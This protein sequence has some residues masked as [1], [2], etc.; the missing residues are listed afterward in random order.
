MARAQV[1]SLIRCNFIDAADRTVTGG[2]RITERSDSPDWPLRAKVV[3][4]LTAAA[5]RC[6]KRRLRGRRRRERRVVTPAGDA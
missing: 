4:M 3:S 1:L 5:S 6:S 2:V